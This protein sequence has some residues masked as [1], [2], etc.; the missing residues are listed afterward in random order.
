IWLIA[1]LWLGYGWLNAGYQKLWG[2]EK[3]AFWN[4]G[5]G[6]KGFATA[7]VTG[8]TAGKG[9]GASYGW[10]AAFLHNFV[11]PNAS[12][13][14]KVVTVSELVIG[15]LLILGLFTGAAAV[16]GLVLNLV[17]MFTGSAGV[18]PA[19]AI[20]AVLLILA[21][22]NAGYLG[23]DRFVFPMMRDRFRPG[24]RKVT[25]AA[26]PPPTAPTPVPAPAP[27]S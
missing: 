19:Y 11:I 17:Y 15:L 1:R 14:A 7:G 12:W 6:V 8:S 13:I 23:L 24:P 21:W 2:S 27:A 18:N 4:G 26:S 10:W 20:V 16:A 25:P 9:S 5:A 3:A 22:R